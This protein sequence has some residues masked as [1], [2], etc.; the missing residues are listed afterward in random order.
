VTALTHILDRARTPDAWI[1]LLAE[2][3]IILSPRTL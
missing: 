3:G 1:A 2:K